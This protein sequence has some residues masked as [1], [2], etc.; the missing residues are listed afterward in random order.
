MLFIN[1]V[2]NLVPQPS[3]RGSSDFWAEIE[4]RRQEF[5]D[6]KASSTTARARN[7]GGAIIIG[8]EREAY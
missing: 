2:P 5:A 3:P 1:D 6:A 8:F 4:K 7:E